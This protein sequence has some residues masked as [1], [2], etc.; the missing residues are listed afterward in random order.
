MQSK[1]CFSLAD[2]VSE[3]PHG[4]VGRAQTGASS[5]EGGGGR[6]SAGRG[7]SRRARP[8]ASHRAHLT[9]W[10]PTLLAAHSAISFLA[11][12]RALSSTLFNPL[13]IL[14]LSTILS[15]LLLSPS[16]STKLYR[17]QNSFFHRGD[18][19]YPIHFLLMKLTILLILLVFLICTFIF[20]WRTLI[21]YCFHVTF[22]SL[23]YI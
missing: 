7:L 20:S 4:P 2:A 16:S 11:I 13:H 19:L 12:A 14:S 17:R 3:G 1:L 9:T 10:P 5:V 23:I 18:F 15:P 8:P 6:D 22:S 21:V